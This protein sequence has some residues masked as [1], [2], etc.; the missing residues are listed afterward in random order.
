[1]AEVL[2]LLLFFLAA[3]MQW[4]NDLGIRQARSAIGIWNRWLQKHGLHVWPAALLVP[5]A[6]AGIIDLAVDQFLPQAILTFLV[7]FCLLP[8]NE[9]YARGK[10]VTD[11]V[12][13]NERE[14]ALAAVA[15]W[16][17]SDVVI[18]DSEKRISNRLL[19]VCA[20]RLHHDLV[21]VLFWYAL[22][23]VAGAVLYFAGRNFS[24]LA[25]R[26]YRDSPLVALLEFPPA[27]F[28][29][30]L[31]CLAGNFAP[32]AGW[33][34]KVDVEKAALAAGDLAGETIVLERVQ[35]YW[36]MLLRVLYCAVAATIIFWL[37]AH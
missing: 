35:V 18:E 34:F 33:L 8:L 23:G 32:A 25:Q 6:L 29:A 11:A 31:C 27:C 2:A 24:G 13:C 22:L 10:E 12:Y 26:Q 4:L 20:F 1:M 14:Q 7:F 3:Q 17:P 9:F 36:R 5:A 28:F 16:M 37:A 19:G 15:A 30:G 21:A